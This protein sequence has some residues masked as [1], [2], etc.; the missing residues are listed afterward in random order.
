MSSMTRRD[1]FGSEYFG[2]TTLLLTQTRYFPAGRR[3]M[4]YVPSAASFAE[5]ALP[6]AGWKTT[7]PLTSG[8]P[9]RLTFPETLASAPRAGAAQH[10]AT[11][12]TNAQYVLI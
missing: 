8:L 9:S 11:S 10:T 7:S 3:P 6:F 1:V 2:G 4:L 12:N 5:K